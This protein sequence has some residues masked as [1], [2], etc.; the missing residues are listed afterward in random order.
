LVEAHGQHA[1]LS[2]VIAELQRAG[3][4]AEE[5][6]AKAVEELEEHK[7]A[8]ACNATAQDNKIRVCGAQPSL[9]GPSMSFEWALNVL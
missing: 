6:K 8:A 2:K 9:N 1:A 5:A 7:I 3:V 4:K